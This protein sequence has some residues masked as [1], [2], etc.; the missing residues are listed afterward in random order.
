MKVYWNAFKHSLRLPQKQ[1]VFAL[2][3]IG[4]DIAVIYLFMLLGLASLPAL[5]EQ[6]LMNESSDVPIHIFF[7]LIYFFIFYYLILAII[8]FTALSAIAYIAKLV[9]GG[10]ERKLH[11]AILWKMAAFSMTLPIILFT[12]IS[13]VYSLSEWF[14]FFSIIYIFFILVKI[15][16]IYPKR[17]KR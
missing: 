6:I 16:L 7:F 13:F 12:A 2:N 17:K 3:R 5:Y 15:I 14:L 11:Y 10:L 1:S 8:V 4:M 9:A